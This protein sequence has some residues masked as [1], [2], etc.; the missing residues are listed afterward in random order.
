V[1][2]TFQGWLALTEAGPGEGSL[3]LYPNAKI[4]MAYILL[5]PFFEPPT[6]DAD[7]LDAEKWRLNLES[8]WF[9]GTFAD[10]SQLVSSNSHPHLRLEECLVSVP[11]M[12]PGDSVWWHTDVSPCSTVNTLPALN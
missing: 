5:R 1:L 3:L 11:R 9:P 6:N 10:D 12:F 8:S 2:R 7:I 4:V